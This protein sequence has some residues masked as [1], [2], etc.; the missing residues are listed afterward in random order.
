MVELGKNAGFGEKRL[1]ILGIGDP[2]GVR[3]L[4]RNRTVEVV[5]LGKVNPSEP[6]W[7]SNLITR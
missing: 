7:P 4:D 6:P 5:V 1:D 2:F 3:N